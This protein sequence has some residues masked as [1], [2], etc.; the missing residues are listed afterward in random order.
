MTVL[1]FTGRTIGK[2]GKTGLATFLHIYVA[3]WDTDENLPIMFAEYRHRYDEDGYLKDDLALA[4]TE[5]FWEDELSEPSERAEEDD[6]DYSIPSWKYGLS[7][8]YA[9]WHNTA[10]P[11]LSEM[12][13]AKSHV[14]QSVLLREQFLRDDTLTANGYQF[15][16]YMPLPRGEFVSFARKKD[17]PP[18]Q[19]QW[20]KADGLRTIPRYI[21]MDEQ[22]TWEEIPT[23]PYT[24]P[25]LPVRRR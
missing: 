17:T 20:L 13:Q 8:F 24:S 9:I 21:R 6:K 14:E 19:S 5:Q 22:T 15:L 4:I 11:S 23:T 16:R 2:G 1:D 18:E 7:N 3:G 25:R 10:G 12:S